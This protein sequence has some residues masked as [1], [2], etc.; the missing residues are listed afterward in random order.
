[1]TGF[2]DAAPNGAR[3]CFPWSF[4]HGFAVGYMTAP[5]TRA[6]DQVLKMGSLRPQ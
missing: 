6:A 3:R 2:P 1:M 5:A 4:T